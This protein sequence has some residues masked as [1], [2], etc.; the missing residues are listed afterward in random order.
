MRSRLLKLQVSD[1]LQQH[2]NVIGRMGDRLAL[3]FDLPGHELVKAARHRCH[4]PAIIAL[5]PHWVAERRLP[6]GDA[7]PSSGYHG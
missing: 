6:I 7:V 1:G 2:A 3:P 4:R 5:N